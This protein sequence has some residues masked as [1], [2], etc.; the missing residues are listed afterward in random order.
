MIFIRTI[1]LFLLLGVGVTGVYYLGYQSG[2]G[3]ARRESRQIN[4]V[5]RDVNG[6]QRSHHS[7]P[8]ETVAAGLDTSDTDAAG[9]S[10]AVMSGL[11]ATVSSGTDTEDLY[12]QFEQLLEQ[13][14]WY[15]LERWL[16]THQ[17]VLSVE[18]EYGETLVNTIKQKANKYDAVALRRILR[19]YLSAVPGHNEALF[20]L[21]DLQQMGGL[22]E[23]ALESLLEILDNPQDSEVVR[24]ARRQAD[25]IINLVAT[26]LRNQT[27]M[28]QREAWWRYISQRLPMSDRY[29]Y[30]WARALA[31]V[32]RWSEARRVLMETGTSDVSQA[33][34]DQLL[35]L[36][37]NSE[38]GL[39][40]Q[41]DGSRMLAVAHGADGGRFTLLVD[42]G[43]SVTSLS[44]AALRRLSATRLNQQVK[45]QTASGVVSARVFEVPEIE[46]QGRNFNAL[47]VI[48]LPVELPGL[49]GLLGFDVLQQLSLSPLNSKSG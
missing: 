9:R 36:I 35:T 13:E 5:G 46:V 44:N 26:E 7:M 15:A 6:Q 17:T 41:R 22:R 19:A 12:I 45:I 29:R 18:V 14:A 10:T 4:L 27:A 31:D 34:L 3:E 43:A 37:D 42:T 11:S 2:L 33:D 38:Q 30:E 8:A 20:M 21:S 39:Q 16:V 32:Q 40:F 23:A 28:A 24:L 47:R 49:D 25:Q 48:E 1:L